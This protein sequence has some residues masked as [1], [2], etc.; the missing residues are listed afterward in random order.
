[1][2]VVIKLLDP[3][4]G[5]FTIKAEF[6]IVGEEAPERVDA[7]LSMQAVYDEEGE[8]VGASLRRYKFQFRTEEAFYYFPI[9]M[10]SIDTFNKA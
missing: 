5:G 8:N 7:P 10:D 3:C 9:A 6:A 2:A 1:M 4:E